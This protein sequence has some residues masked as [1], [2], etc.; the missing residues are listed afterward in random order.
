HPSDIARAEPTL[1]DP[2]RRTHTE[3][4]LQE[5]LKPQPAKP[6]AAVLRSFETRDGFQMQLVAR[7]PLV[8]DPIA[9]A[10]DENGDL[11]VCEMRDYPYKP[12]ANQQ[13]LGT[14]RLLRDTDGDG[15]FDVSHV[16]ADQLL[17]PGG[18]APWKGGVFVAA[19]PDIWYLRDTDGD[20]RADVR[21]KV[22]TG[23]GTDNQ[24]AMV[25]NLKW[26]LDH[27]IYGSTAGNGGRIRSVDVAAG[28]GQQ[29]IS[30]NGRDFRFDPVGGRFEA[31]TGTVQFG[32]TFDDW[33]NRFM[34]S[35]SRPLQ[36]AVLP[37]HYLE[38]N[39]YLPVPSAIH[40][41]TPRAVPIFRISPLER[42]RMI[43][44]SRRIASGQRSPDASGAS[45]HV[46][47]AAAGVTI[48]RG[49]AYP[50]RYY[51][52]V[53]LGGAQNNLIHRRV[54]VPSGVTFDS[55][56]ADQGTEF[57]RSSDNWFRPVNFVNAP[58]GTLYVLDMSREVL[59]TIH[60]PLD[61]TKFLDFTRG[62]QHGR[63][64]RLA[65][66]DFRYPGPPRLGAADA[67]ALVAALDS[68]H[69]WWRDTA[70][71]L[72]YERQDLEA[73]EPLRHVLTDGRRPVARLYALYALDGLAQLTDSDLLT[74]LKSG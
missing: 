41:L 42:W 58:D 53:F 11:Y 47:D 40:N 67:A 45:H 12:R 50:A 69:G 10:F 70:H 18:V 28:G 44:S 39:P 22:Y 46:I 33:G 2:G 64:Y 23:F 7:E 25:N 15:V 68:P 27:R 20:H 72:I 31:I 35:E 3:R 26:G 66:P 36:N 56:R 65:P 16:F 8:N 6:I 57:V 29:P 9:A 61:V 49:G 52:N 24:Q 4:E 13:P 21:R 34:C 30:V 32:N 55:Q 5:F 17:W 60:V 51:G 71:R 37:Q 1:D 48:Y 74:A 54:L 59:E 62:R 38:R 73:V 63:I 43:R 14:V 19:P